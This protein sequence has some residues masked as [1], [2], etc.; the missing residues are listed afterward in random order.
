MAELEDRWRKSQEDRYM[1]ELKFKEVLKGLANNNEGTKLLRIREKYHRFLENEDRR[2]QRN[3]QML[4]TLDKIDSQAN[5]LAAKTERLRLLKNP[6]CF[7]Q[8]HYEAYMKRMYPTWKIS[9]DEDEYLS[10]KNKEVFYPSSHKQRREAMPSNSHKRGGNVSRKLIYNNSPYVNKSPY[11]TNNVLDDRKLGSVRLSNAGSPDNHSRQSR[12]ENSGQLDLN[13]EFSNINLNSTRKNG[14]SRALSAEQD[15]NTSKDLLNLSLSDDI[16]IND[17]MMPA[18]VRAA[19]E[20]PLNRSISSSPSYARIKEDVIREPSRANANPETLMDKHDCNNPASGIGSALNKELADVGEGKDSEFDNKSDIEKLDSVSSKKKVSKRP[21]VQEDVEEGKPCFVI[22]QPTPDIGLSSSEEDFERKGSKPSENSKINVEPMNPSYQE[23][24]EAEVSEGER[25]D[26]VTNVRKEEIGHSP[27]EEQ[28]P[29]HFLGGNVEGPYQFSSSDADYDELENQMAAM[30]E[31]R[32]NDESIPKVSDDIESESKPDVEGQDAEQH[33]SHDSSNKGKSDFLPEERKYDMCED[34]V[35]DEGRL[36]K[37][38]EFTKIQENGEESADGHRKDYIK[39]EEEENAK[40]TK[41]NDRKVKSYD[42]ERDYEAGSS[43]MD[44]N[45]EI[46]DEDHIVNADGS[47]YHVDK[48]IT[49]VNESGN[50]DVVVEENS[51]AHL[52]GQTV[53]EEAESQLENEETNDYYPEEHKDGVVEGNFPAHLERQR[54]PEEAESQL[55]KEETIEPNPSVEQKEFPDY[56]DAAERDYADFEQVR[57]EQHFSHENLENTEGRDEEKA[58]V[59]AQSDEEQND[60]SPEYF[61]EREEVQNERFI[62]ENLNE[63]PASKTVDNDESKNLEGADEEDE[64]N[65]VNVQQGIQEQEEYIADEFKDEQGNREENLGS[66]FEDREVVRRDEYEREFTNQEEDNGE[67]VRQGEEIERQYETEEQ[68]NYQKQEIDEGEFDNQDVS[69]HEGESNRQYTEDENVYERQDYESAENEGDEIQR[70]DDQ[71]IVEEVEGNVIPE[72]EEYE[73]YTEEQ[74]IEEPER[75]N[76]VEEP[77]EPSHYDPR[78]RQQEERYESNVEEH[79][80]YE[81]EA[82]EQEYDRYR[83]YVRHETVSEEGNRYHHEEENKEEG[84]IQPDV[85]ERDQS[86]NVEDQRAMEEVTAES[87]GLVEGEYSNQE[88]E[89]EVNEK[90]EGRYEERVEDDQAY[91]KDVQESQKFVNEDHGNEKEETQTLSPE[92]VEHRQEVVTP[93]SN[94]S[95]NA[96]IENQSHEDTLKQE[97]RNEKVVEEIP[98]VEEKTVP[99]EIKEEANVVVKEVKKENVVRKEKKENE[100][101]ASSLSVEKH[102]RTAKESTPANSRQSARQLGKKEYDPHKV[103]KLKSTIRKFQLKKDNKPDK[104]GRK[105]ID[106]KK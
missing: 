11:S 59:R 74:F 87:S 98:H 93:E 71:V 23:I 95:E 34:D 3:D 53:Q 77:E 32:G 92:N 31:R 45:S 26:S 7:S 86:S 85:E 90:N 89:H 41:T 97:I 65:T 50:S 56:E 106:S 79:E 48:S 49:E 54:A 17:G 62:E 9:E 60:D 38:V 57:E 24:S 22:T 42:S 18:E 84:E 4:R 16:P 103:E 51:P 70:K 66:H 28:S 75:L 82:E 6:F 39:Q 21:I 27:N 99:E 73:R 10:S 36:D 13:H 2:N 104:T 29:R 55:Q 80:Q 8:L 46:L 69:H 40:L 43:S 14:N 101:V 30:V 33:K 15:E 88:K 78:D 52:V 68:E 20:K 47:T 19:D 100:A 91:D 35:M 67:Y 5:I 83:D 1:L 58:N 102:E 37:N 61:S 72:Q 44:V 25:V 105:G 12:G 63:D 81:R 76:A 94:I 96:E 64:Y